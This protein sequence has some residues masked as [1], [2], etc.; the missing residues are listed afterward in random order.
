MQAATLKEEAGASIMT[1]LFLRVR[2]WLHCER[3]MQFRVFRVLEEYTGSWL[4]GS[5][6]WLKSSN[7]EV[8]I[9]NP[10]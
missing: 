2:E 9:F 10:M 7:K 8:A 3:N 5:S 6:N 4:H 1:C